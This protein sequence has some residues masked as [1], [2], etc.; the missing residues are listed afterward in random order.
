MQKPK[1]LVI[2]G[3]T[4]SGK[5][6]LSVSLA[7]KFDGEV[8]SADSRQVYRGMDIGTA[9]V[10]KEEMQDVPHHLLDVASPNEVYT[11]LDFA[12][13]AKTAIEDIRSREKLPIIAGGTFFYIDVLLGKISVP[14]VEPNLSL[15]AEL[16]EKTTDELLKIL[17]KIDPEKYQTIESKNRR[18]V[19]RA[20]EVAKKLGKVPSTKVSNPDYD[21]L[22]LGLIVDFDQ[23][24]DVIKKRLLERLE[25]GMLEEVEEL[26]KSGVTHERLESFGLEYRYASRY[27]RNLMTYDE[28]IDEITNKSRQFA[29]RQMTWLKRDQSIKWFTPKDPHILKEVEEFTSKN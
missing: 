27:L 13:D 7:K 21:V 15:R 23:H 17:E 12:R 10:S 8:I 18:R 14:E 6:G 4:A 16:E 19:I 3:P 29:K 20:I 11:A 2:V 1:V 22:T 26:L 24:K 5:T 9:K 25:A 28:M